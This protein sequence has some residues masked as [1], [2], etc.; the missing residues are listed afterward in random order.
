MDSVAVD[1]GFEKALGAALGDDLDA[2]IDPSAPMR[3]AGASVDPADR[4]FPRASSRCPKHVAAP[5]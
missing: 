4:R 3:W 5:D 2:P 1:K